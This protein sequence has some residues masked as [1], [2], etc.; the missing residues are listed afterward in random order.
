MSTVLSRNKQITYTGRYLSVYSSA[1]TDTVFQLSPLLLDPRL[2]S[3]SDAY[4]EYRFTRVKVRV[5]CFRSD[6]SSAIAYPATIAYTSVLPSSN[7]STDLEYGQFE[8][9]ATGNGTVGAPWPQLHLNK[10]LLTTNAPKWFRRGTA[11]DDLLEL[12]GQI[13]IRQA[14]G[15]GTYN[16]S[17][18]IEYTVQLQGPTATA[19]TSAPSSELVGKLAA[20][21]L[22]VPRPLESDVKLDDAVDLTPLFKRDGM[23]IISER[24]VEKATRALKGK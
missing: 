4:Q 12:Q 5:F 18:D 24:D 13:M 10:R 17:I 19:L 23:V 14:Q 16:A 6:S 3:V 7:P 1:V 21:R 15:F 20:L 11:Y 22:A 9:C 2:V 8:V